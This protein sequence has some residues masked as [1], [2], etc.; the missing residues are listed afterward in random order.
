[1]YLIP[2]KSMV[3]TAVVLFL[4][5]DLQPRSHTARIWTA[6]FPPAQQTQPQTQS[7]N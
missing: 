3:A 5:F 7:E 2:W 6:L 4:L 1:M